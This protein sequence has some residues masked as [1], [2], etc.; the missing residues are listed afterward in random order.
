[1]RLSANIFLMKH[2]KISGESNG[3]EQVI[4]VLYS[5][6]THLCKPL[7]IEMTLEDNERNK[8]AIFHFFYFTLQYTAQQTPT[9]Q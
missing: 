3:A 9:C 4:Y 7:L 2:G 6:K 8:A 5:I 1:M